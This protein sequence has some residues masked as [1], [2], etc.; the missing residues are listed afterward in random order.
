[1]SI[2]TLLDHW[3]LALLLVTWAVIGIVSVKSR[4]DWRQRRFTRQ[5]NFSLNTLVE[6]D[7]STTL[8][9]RTLLEDSAV[10]VWL[11]EFGVS[12][13]LKAAKHTTL[14]KPFL[15]IA[16]AHDRDL[17][18]I[19]VLNVLSERFSDA[20]LARAIGIPTKIDTFLYGLTWE[21]YG[22]MKT[23]KLRVIVIKR[24]DLENMFDPSGQCKI[25]VAEESHRP[26]IKT[27]RRMYELWTSANQTDRDMIREVELGMPAYLE[28]SLSPNA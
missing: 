9:L 6:C 11:N 13:V 26:R 19:A 3:E 5:V 25:D 17:V 16:K 21:H 4:Y 28:S 12:R 18:M 27:L 22:E 8:H 15:N 1:M 10:N 23:Q 24:S 20:F 7:G 2:N 14:G